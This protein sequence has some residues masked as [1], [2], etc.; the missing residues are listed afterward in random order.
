MLKPRYI[1]I[2][3][4]L[5]AGKTT[6][7]LRLAELLKKQ[8]IRVGLITNDQST[9]LVDTTL[10]D[11][12]GFPTEEIPGGCFCC[13]FHSLIEAAEKLTTSTQPEVFIAE[14][15]GSC[16]DLRA[17]VSYPLQRMY[18][19]DFKVAPL[20][21]LVDPIRAQRILGLK[22]G[23]QFTPKVM[24]IY[25]KQLEEADIIVINKTDLIQ[26]AE[27]NELEAALLK[28]W[29]AARVMRICARSGE[30]I[31]AWLQAILTD[32]LPSRSAMDVDYDLYADGEALLGWLNL[33][34]D[35]GVADPTTNEF[36]GNRFLLE[37][38]SRLEQALAG[39]I[40]DVAHLKMTL[41][42]GEGPDIGVVNLVRAGTM[43]EAS[44]TLTD[45]LADGEL[46]LNLRAEGD[47]EELRECVERT[48]Q[49][50]CATYRIEALVREINAFRP[51]RPVP[52]HR[53][54]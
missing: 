17:T 43:P 32:E 23:K 15:V 8:E 47:P 37:L 54:G 50:V 2:G 48:L 6:A 28:K 29:P 7:I 42:P 3:G 40:G 33:A 9:G 19:D 12:H 26:E 24:Y 27:L 11:A 52:V 41:I 18:G 31:D 44:H 38:A 46:L 22:D 10:L 13:K 16:T 1:M 35:L 45:P 21:V 5:G 53:M 14:P 36:D 25:E 20:S 4:F 34:A 49:E 39:G 30:G 51:G